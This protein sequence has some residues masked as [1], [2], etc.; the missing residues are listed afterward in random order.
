MSWDEMRS[1][2]CS[3]Y[4]TFLKMREQHNV[5]SMTELQCLRDDKMAHNS[6]LNVSKCSKMFISANSKQNSKKVNTKMSKQVTQNR[7]QQ[8]SAINTCF[9]FFLLLLSFSFSPSH[10][11]P[12]SASLPPSQ[13]LVVGSV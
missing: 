11:S 3:L 2:F 10:L 6:L 8:S 5:C 1:M 13:Q 12:L 9:S 4:N 7:T